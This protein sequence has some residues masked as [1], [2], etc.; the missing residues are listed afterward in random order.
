M[1]RMVGREESGFSC[2]C[3]IPPRERSGEGGRVECKNT[4]GSSGDGCDR[5]DRLEGEVRDSH[6]SCTL[7]RIKQLDEEIDC[8]TAITKLNKLPQVCG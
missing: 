2:C 3:T 6:V 5:I 4:G 7:P 8:K 1:K